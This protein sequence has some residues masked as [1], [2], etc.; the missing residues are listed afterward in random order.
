[1][2]PHVI[3]G[4]G[5]QLPVTHIGRTQTPATPPLKLTNIL[6]T[7]GII[8]SLISVRKFTMDNSCSVEFDPFGFSVKDLRTKKEIHMCNCCIPQSAEAF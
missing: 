2:T 6:V 8:K 7:H 1:M 5:N 3:V 4:N